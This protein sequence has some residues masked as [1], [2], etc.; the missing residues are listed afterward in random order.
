M[1]LMKARPSHLPIQ[2]GD[3]TV[4]VGVSPTSLFRDV[5]VPFTGRSSHVTAH[6]LAEEMENDDRRQD[7]SNSSERDLWH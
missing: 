7:Q 2:S 3:A 5:N 6:P 1:A 4:G